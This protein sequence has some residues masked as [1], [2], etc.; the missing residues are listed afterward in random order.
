MAR[1]D[2]DKME[3]VGRIGKLIY[4]SYNG[5]TY[6]RSYPREYHFKT[7]PEERP[8]VNMFSQASLYFKFLPEPL[9]QVW[10]AAASKER[11]NCRNLFIKVNFNA[12]SA[13]S[14]VPYYEAMSFSHGNLALPLNMKLSSGTDEESLL[15]TWDFVAERPY[16]SPDDRLWIVEIHTS[17]PFQV[18][19]VKDVT[20]KRSDGRCEFRLRR[21]L[22]EEA[23]LYCFF[24]NPDETQFSTTHYF[25]TPAE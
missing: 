18:N 2:P 11:Y 7:P 21:H 9:V 16:V 17:T 23:H 20:A 13:D 3:I 19:I 14:S 8:A 1:Y 24:G 6:V 25:R 15:L 4:Y 22:G 5:V 10:R 12:F